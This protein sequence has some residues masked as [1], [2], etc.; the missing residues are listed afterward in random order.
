MGTS[1]GSIAWEAQGLQWWRGIE[2]QFGGERFHLAMKMGPSEVMFFLKKK[3][4]STC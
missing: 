1:H 2:L 4:T 3:V